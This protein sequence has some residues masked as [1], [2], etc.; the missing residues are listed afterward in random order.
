MTCQ[1]D[2]ILPEGAVQQNNKSK[3]NWQGDKEFLN[4]IEIVSEIA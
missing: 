2:P 1:K 4:Q 3:Q